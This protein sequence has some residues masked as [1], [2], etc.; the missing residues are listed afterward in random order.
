MICAPA[1]ANMYA[2]TGRKTSGSSEGITSSPIESAPM[3]IAPASSHS[4]LA[5]GRPIPG[6]FMQVAV[7]VGPD[8]VIRP[9]RTS[10]T[11]FLRSSTPCFAA[12]SC[13]SSGVIA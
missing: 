9:V 8:V 2:C 1:V 6:G 11:S 10:T 13:R 5:A 3:H 12:V 7:E 4:H